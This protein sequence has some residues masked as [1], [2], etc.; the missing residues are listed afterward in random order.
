MKRMITLLLCGLMLLSMAAC[1]RTRPEETP[2][3]D[4]YF[5]EADLKEANGRGALR[6]ETAYLP[7]LEGADPEETAKG[8][9]EALLQGPLDGTLTSPIPVGTNL[10]SLKLEGGRAV[11]DL[12]ASYGSLSGVGLTLADYAVALTLTQVPEIGSVKITVRGQELAYRDRQI[13][14][15][16]D[17]LLVP[18]EDVVS[19]VTAVLY[20]LNGE[21]ALTPEERTLDLYEGDTQVYAVARALENGPESKEL[22]AVMPEGFRVKSVWLEEDVCYVNLSSAMLEGLP[23]KTELQTAVYSL[24]KSL[25]SLDTVSEVRF[26]V[27]GEFA[28][29]YGT[30]DISEPYIFVDQ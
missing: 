25:C 4:L 1:G 23:Q 11:V 14:L 28:K 12:T 3:Y 9:M 13:F 24:A 20:F 6:A 22:S 16:R 19:T 26:L 15:S 30:V 21:G 2:S 5:M 27:D 10:L 7:E 18:E 29:Q 8:L 17:V